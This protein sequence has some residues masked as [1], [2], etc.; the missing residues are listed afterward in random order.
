MHAKTH[1]LTSNIPIKKCFWGWIYWHESWYLLWVFLWS[2]YD[3]TAMS[4]LHRPRKVVNN[5][6]FLNFLPKQFLVLSNVVVGGYINTDR[7]SNCNV[8]KLYHHTPCMQCDPVLRSAVLTNE[9]WPC[10][11]DDLTALNFICHAQGRI[12]PRQYFPILRRRILPLREHRRHQLPRHLQLGGRDDGVPHS[13]RKFTLP[14][15]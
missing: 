5:S 12:F 3:F 8:L 7:V 2:W 13:A 6:Q 15:Y 10:K 9:N 11:Q 4:W 14:S 1:L